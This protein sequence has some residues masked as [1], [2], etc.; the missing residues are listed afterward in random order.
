MA[1]G[2]PGARHALEI[3]KSELERAMR[4]CGVRSLA[5]I[6]PDLLYGKP[7]A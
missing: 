7:H 4:L 3:L 5:D 2:E 1:A 6:S